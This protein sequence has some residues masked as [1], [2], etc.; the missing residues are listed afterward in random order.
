MILLVLLLISP[1][2]ARKPDP[3]VPWYP[4]HVTA[5]TLTPNG[6]NRD[7]GPFSS[8]DAGYTTSD[9]VDLAVDNAFNYFYEI[10][11]EFAGLRTN[12][13]IND[14]YVMWVP[15]AQ[16][17]A[18]GVTYGQGADTVWVT[19]WLRVETADDP[20]DCW[21]K[22]A[23]GVYWGVYY[24]NW[25]HTARPLVPALPHEMLHV[26]IGDPGHTDYRWSLVGLPPPTTPEPSAPPSTKTVV[27]VTMESQIRAACEG[28]F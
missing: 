6:F 3:H 18:S 5:W 9:E 12:V 7:A 4:H 28:H 24:A 27:T 23:P 25:R 8:V 19:L 2:C 26:A 20:G 22:R 10:F 16:S 1:S 15:L 11:P 13:A 14:D 17:W 21:I